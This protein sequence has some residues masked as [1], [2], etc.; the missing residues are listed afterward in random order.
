MKQIKIPLML[1]ER[2]KKEFD[3]NYKI[4]ARANN[5]EGSGEIK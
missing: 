2:L 5:Q 3:Q 4:A 1:I